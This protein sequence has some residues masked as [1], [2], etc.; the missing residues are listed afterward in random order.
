MLQWG[1]VRANFS[2]AMIIQLVE[3][4]AKGRAVELQTRAGDRRVSGKGQG[5]SGVAA[6]SSF[7]A[8]R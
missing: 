2:L 5:G 6:I 7:A 4:P 8:S 1:F 3:P